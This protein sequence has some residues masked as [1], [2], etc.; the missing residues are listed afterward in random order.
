MPARRP[1]GVGATTPRVPGEQNV[2]PYPRNYA[3]ACYLR[4]L[5]VARDAESHRGSGVRYAKE[6]DSVVAQH[7]WTCYSC[8]YRLPPR[9][10]QIHYPFG[11]LP[12][13]ADQIR[14]DG[15]GDA[16]ANLYSVEYEF[17]PNTGGYAVDTCTR[18]SIISM[19]EPGA[20]MNWQFVVPKVAWAQKRRIRKCLYLYLA[21]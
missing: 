5:A 19:P 6:C 13:P 7:C 16:S 9:C 11:L 3:S 12:S 21:F 10:D 2:R 4:G 17:I 20:V 15:S 14:L 18:T 8:R 1:A